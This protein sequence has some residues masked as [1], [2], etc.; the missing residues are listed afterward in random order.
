M[1][2]RNLPLINKDADDAEVPEPVVAEIFVLIQCTL[3]FAMTIG[4]KDEDATVIFNIF[5]R[6]HR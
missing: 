1:K 4:L 5:R 2:F 6:L 3:E